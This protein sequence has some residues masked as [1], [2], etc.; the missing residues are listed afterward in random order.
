M[1]ISQII[2]YIIR[3]TLKIISFLIDYDKT[4]CKN[5][6]VSYRES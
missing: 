4:T 3:F 2:I 1:N 6:P 5:D